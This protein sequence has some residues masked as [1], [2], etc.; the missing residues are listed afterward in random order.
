[1]QYDTSGIVADEVQIKLETQLKELEGEKG[2]RVRVLTYDDSS[3]TLEEIRGA[4]KPDKK[5]VVI[6]FDPTSPNILAFP[7]IG[8]EALAKLRRPF[9][10][11][12]Q[13]RYGNKFFVRDQ[14]EGAAVESSVK[15]LVECLSKTG[16]CAV[17]P[18][19]PDDQYNFTLASSV[20]GGIIAGL[21]STIQFSNPFS[22]SN[23]NSPSGQLV[24]V[25]LFS[26]L[27]ATLFISFGLGPIISRTTEMQPLLQNCL[28]FT[29]SAASP[30]ILR[31]ILR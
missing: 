23:G 18:G 21:A 2:W 8:D 7:Y 22:S 24:W 6:R 25:L 10:V 28:A 29:M 13:S 1:M 30:W 20:A 12:L 26:P 9:Y 5:T 19:L 16:G 17:V 11:E 15:A 31:R 4:W 14:G 27:W 3:P